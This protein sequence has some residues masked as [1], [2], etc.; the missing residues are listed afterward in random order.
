ML[1][2]IYV[3]SHFLPGP[4]DAHLISIQVVSHLNAGPDVRISP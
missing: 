2:P 3:P 4:L 1:T